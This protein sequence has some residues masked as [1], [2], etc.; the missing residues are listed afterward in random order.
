MAELLILGSAPGFPVLERGHSSAILDTGKHRLLIDAGEPCSRSMLAQ[1]IQ[2]TDIDAVLLT[3]GHSDHTAGLPMLIQTAWISGRTKL[4]PIYLPEELINPLQAWLDASYIGPKFL[5]FPLEFF[6]WESRP[7]LEQFDLKINPQ[8]TSHLDDLVKR[9]GPTRFRSYSLRVAHPGFQ[10]LV[11]GDL[12][13][14]RDL[15]AQLREP[16]DL[17]VCELAHFEPE[18]LF[19][20][21]RGKNIPRLLLTHLAPNLSDQTD[22]LLAK[23]RDLLPKTETVV[24]IDGMRIRI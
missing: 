23:A 19:R 22:Q 24:A 11:S 3:H 13:S 9:F 2:A 1:Q 20:F 4:L 14:P 12:G 18:E 7:S 8:A 15:D 6:A 16:P 5:Q 10:I 21:L 17:V